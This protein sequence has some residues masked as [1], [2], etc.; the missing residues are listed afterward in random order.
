GLHM[1]TLELKQRADVHHR[2]VGQGIDDAQ[3]MK[4]PREERAR[5]LADILKRDAGPAAP[6]DALS[7]RTLA[8]FEAAAQ[9][10]MRYG[11]QAIG[12][13][14]VAA[15]QGEDDILA[16]LVLARWA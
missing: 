7:R 11:T 4:H 6:L 2:V 1:A 10:R 5:L 8:V 14:V 12:D 3:W 9:C 15:T 16:P 13:Y